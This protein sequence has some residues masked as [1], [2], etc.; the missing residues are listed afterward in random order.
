[1]TEFLEAPLAT[2]PALSGSI[3]IREA[4]AADNPAL[5]ALTK[6]TPMDGT[7]S[8]RIDRDPDFFALPRARGNSVIFTA[9]CEGQLIG[10][11]S[12]SVH[13]AYIDGRPEKIAH[14]NDLKVHPQFSGRRLAVEL[15]STMEKW[16]RGQEIDIALSLVADGNRRVM[17]LAEGRHGTPKN[18][19]L[20]NFLVDQLLP[21]PWL[22]RSARRFAVQAGPEDLAEVDELL[23]RSNRERNFS[24][25]IATGAES[26]NSLF[27]KTLIARDGGKVIATITVEDTQNLRQNVLI[28]LP[29]S[30]RAALAALRILALPVAKLKVPRLGEPLAILYARRI[31]CAEGH[32]AAL[33]GLLEAARV[34]AFQRNYSFVSVGLH[35]RDPLRLIVA[36]VPRLTFTSHLLA[37]SLLSPDRN[38]LLRNRVPYEDFALL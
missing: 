13:M 10:C 11:I 20:G 7:I 33:R 6:L 15:M 9:R 1:V 34:E 8:L 3:E 37:A 26:R 4:T 19:E 35:D 5:R 29:P 25:V 14:I 36:G 16:L 27:H 23:E 2:Q 38:N 30:Y 32:E 12:A 28:S 18:T 17:V 24:P 22:G 31:A 21:T